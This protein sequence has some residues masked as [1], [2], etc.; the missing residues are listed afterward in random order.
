[1]SKVSFILVLTVFFF[2]QNM[3]I[4]TL[5]PNFALNSFI[6]PESCL[7]CGSFPTNKASNGCGVPPYLTAYVTIFL[8]INSVSFVY[9]KFDHNCS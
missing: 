2:F 8:N 9:T 7:K 3:A 5:F 1:M 4:I 6:F